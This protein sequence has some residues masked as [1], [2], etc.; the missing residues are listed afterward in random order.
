M[1]PE[2]HITGLPYFA[3]SARTYRAEDFVGAKPVSCRER[4][5][6]VSPKCSRSKPQIA[7]GSRGYTETEDLS[8]CQQAWLLKTPIWEKIRNNVA[9]EYPI[10]DL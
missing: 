2:P 8:C 10:S 6:N 7:P 4:H 9:S 5:I 1:R 3:H